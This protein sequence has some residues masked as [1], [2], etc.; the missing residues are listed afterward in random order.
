MTEPERSALVDLATESWRFT[1]VFC[2]MLARLDAGEKAR[3]ESQL[4][5]YSKRLTESLEAAGL[6]LV[7]LEEQPFDPGIAATPLNVA[8]FAPEDRLVVDQM[9]EPTILGPDGVLRTGTV[10]LRKEAR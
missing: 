8:D 3:Y 4:R 10:L 6:R 7:N 5:W 2:R 1:K 9:L